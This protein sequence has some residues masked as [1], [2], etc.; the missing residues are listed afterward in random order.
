MNMADLGLEKSENV[1]QERAQ[2]C[3]DVEVVNPG[4]VEGWDAQMESLEGATPFHSSAWAAVLNETYGFEPAYLV[5]RRDGKPAVVMPMMKV[6]SSLTGR[7]F[8]SL[9]FS[10]CCDPIGEEQTNFAPLIKLAIEQASRQGCKYVEWRTRQ[11]LFPDEP[12]WNTYYGHTLALDGKEGAIFSRLSSN[13][14]RNIRRAEREK[15][16]VQFGDD[17]NSVKEFYRL[18]CQ[19]RKEHG[20]PPQP[21]NF[22]HKIWEQVIRQKRGLVILARHQGKYVGGAV[23]FT[24]ASGAV[25]KFGASDKR[26]QAVRANN[27]IMWEAIKWCGRRSLVSLDFGRTDLSAEGLRRFKLGWGCTEFPILYHRFDL[28]RNRFLAGTDRQLPFAGLVRRM[29]VFLSRQLG[30]VIYKHFA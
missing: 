26:Y 27:L 28:S 14:R 11:T 10:D 6:V 12:V 22:F 20:V 15:V 8:V 24:F 29:P 16:L 25:Y 21:F 19:T 30:R 17:L 5:R 7:R 2:A 3:G 4:L 1:E 9:P 18:H 23:F 13:T